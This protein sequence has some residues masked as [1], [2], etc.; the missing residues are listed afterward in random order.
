M[1]RTTRRTILKAGLAGTALAAAGAS[2]ASGC[3]AAAPAVTPSPTPLRKPKEPVSKTIL[4][5]GGTGFLGPH[6][7][8]YARSRGHTLTLFNRGK[9]HTELFP[10]LEKLHGDRDGHLE[11]LVGRKWD[12]VIDTSG[13]FPRLVK[14]SAELLAPN[15]GQYVFVSSISVYADPVPAHASESTP[16]ATMPDP[17]VEDMQFYGALKARCEQA[18]EAAMP[19]RVTNVRPGLIVGPG[20]PTDRFTYWPA[21]LAKGGEVLAPGSGED[22]GQLI[23]ARDLGAWLVHAVETGTMGVF[24]AVGPATTM[25]MKDMLGACETAARGMAAP[26]STLT[27][28]DTAFLEKMEVAPWMELPVWTGGDPGFATIDAKKAIAAGLTFRPIL[29]TARD[30]LT[31]WKTLPEE[32]RA[33]PKAGLAPDKEAA[34]LAAWKKAHA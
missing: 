21:R 18:A 11:A 23:D 1:T 12:A 5:L 3:G 26:A 34:V 25:T 17:T 31:W 20:D 15:V 16:V 6:I 33:A 19:G 9:T 13:Y 30:T 28:V 2:L 4:V 14:A 22:P 7:V 29:D 27:W 8:E 24:N 10:E 32:R